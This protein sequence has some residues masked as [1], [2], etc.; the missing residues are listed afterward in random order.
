MVVEFRFLKLSC[1]CALSFFT[2]QS[3]SPLSPLPL[4]KKKNQNVPQSRKHPNQPQL[5]TTSPI[6]K[7]QKP[8][9][10]AYRRKDNSV[11]SRKWALAAKL[12]RRESTLRKK[13]KF[14]DKDCSHGR[15]FFFGFNGR[16]L[17]AS[18][19]SC[20]SAVGETHNQGVRSDGETV[21]L[22]FFRQGGGWKDQ[23]EFK[24]ARFTDEILW[25]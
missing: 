10:Y 15:I 20:R 11:E 9:H 24:K 18:G 2:F 5:S 22:R 4:P 21:G 17:G 14:T 6:S 16:K 19:F 3:F 12:R 1:S 7:G 23:S 25:R 13:K 8:E